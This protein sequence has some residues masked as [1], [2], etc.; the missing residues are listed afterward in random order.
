MKLAQLGVAIPYQ[1]MRLGMFVVADVINRA[2]KEGRRVGC[3]YVT[4]DSQPSLV[5]WYEC[6]GFERNRLR[7]DRRVQDALA[8]GRD[9][10]AIAVSMRYD[11]RK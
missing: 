2:R 1:R 9:P 8:H 6:Q 11:L 7:Q 10:A 4:L 5:S 3:R